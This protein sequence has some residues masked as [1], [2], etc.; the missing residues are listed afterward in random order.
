MKKRKLLLALVA[1]FA[2]SSCSIQDL[3]F[4][5]KKDN[6]Q[7]QDDNS[8]SGDPAKTTEWTTAQ[9]N[10]MKSYFNG[11][12]LPYFELPAGMSWTDEYFEEYKCLS[13]EVTANKLNECVA[14]I[15]KN[16]AYVAIEDDEYGAKQ[17]NVATSLPENSDY[18]FL[19]QVYYQSSVT[20]IDVYLRAKPY[21]TWPTSKISELLDELDLEVSLPVFTTQEDF[22]F[23]C[24]VVYP[25]EDDED[26]LAYVYVEAYGPDDSEVT[27]IDYVSLFDEELYYIEEDSSGYILSAKDKSCTIQVLD[28]LT[29]TEDWELATL[30]GFSVYV[31][32]YIPDYSMSIV[33]EYEMIAVEGSVDLTLELGIDVVAESVT[34][35]SSDISIATV[36]NA[37]HVVGVSEG[38]VT[39]TASYSTLGSCTT[40]VY[41]VDEVPT[42]FTSAQI[43]EI[44]KIHNVEGITVPFFKYIDTVE[45][46]S[47]E[48]YVSFVGKTISIDQLY[49][50]YDSLV[51]AGWHDF[52]S[53][54]YA[55]WIAAKYF[56]T[57][58]QAMQYVH[59]QL[60]YLAFEKEFEIESV[61]Y[62]V[63]ANIYCF[64]EGTDGSEYSLTGGK[65]GMDLFDEFVYSYSD[66]VDLLNDLLEEGGL[67]TIP[68]FP[69]E[70][71][72]ARYYVGL[73]TETN[74]Y[75]F[76]AY[77]TVVTLSDLKTA[78]E[79]K[80]F[81]CEV[82]DVPA[83]SDAEAYS[84]LSGAS[85]D[86]KLTFVAYV[87]NG[88]VEMYFKV[89]GNGA[90]FDF[91]NSITDTSGEI[92]GF[93]FS[94]ALGTNPNS[95]VPAYNANKKE[96]RLY[97]GNT[98]TIEGPSLTSI[99]IASTCTESKNDGTLTCDTGT[100]TSVTGGYQWT[101]N[102][103][104]VTFTVATG[105]QFH[106]DSI[107]IN[108]VTE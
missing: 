106:I 70:L 90:F 68:E 23:Y 87:R 74:K 11:E 8:S 92:D 63:S 50:Y 67:E 12:V 5:K 77:E 66:A 18:I 48:E 35:T 105:K 9:Q 59:S 14:N 76:V 71:P 17:F 95:A 21:K 10:M 100:L 82:V 39:I 3:M 54:T 60:G 6:Q 103:T 57:V 30:P 47:A 22:E 25:E 83:T 36:D 29:I 15:K 79:A 80:N 56:D 94:T 31:S 28:M 65:F 107:S 102:A 37:G 7:Q 51:E 93:S 13:A 32:E 49:D 26:S 45:Y 43:A 81:T 73:N 97:I 98:L 104:S 85:Q 33:E 40:T 2:L 72:A 89:I 78:L 20:A 58:E 1:G 75:E 27:S 62:V 55:A 34:F 4:W 41:V 69:E 46:V 19:V 84:Y 61:T 52:Y 53:E 38:E 108:G 101:G 16:S 96:L 86:E 42:A 88:N 64:V 99:F 24:G 44:N 91:K